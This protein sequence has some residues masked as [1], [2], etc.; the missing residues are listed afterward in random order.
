MK[1]GLCLL[2]ACLLICS[3]AVCAMAAQ[4]GPVITMQPQSPNIPH[5]G[6]AIYTVKATGSN[7]SATWYMEWQGKT[8]TISEL[9][10][11]MQPWEAYA[12]EA[13]GP[14]KLDDNT[15]AFI[16][17]GIERDLDGARIWCVIEDGHYDVTSRKAYVM[18]GNSFTAPEILDIP[19]DVT[20]EQGA[21]AEI[22][23]VA[24]APEGTQLSFVWYET[25][26]GR[27]EDMRAVNRGE[28]TTDY[29]LCDTSVVGTRNYLCKVES[30][31]GGLIYSSIVQVTV[32][33]KSQVVEAPEI[34]TKQLPEATAG[35]AYDA[36]LRC[37]D[38]NASFSVYF[39]PGKKNEFEQTGLSLSKDG[40][41]T[42]TPQN[43]GSFTFCICAAGAGG[44]DYWEYTLTVN[45]PKPQETEPVAPTTVPGATEPSAVPGPGGETVKP[46]IKPAPT[47]PTQEEPMQGG[48]PWWALVL[49]GVLA[50]GAGVVT[51]LLLAR[52]KS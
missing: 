5:Y 43:A 28:E 18:V 32:I 29:L 23:C 22:R 2:L 37:S 33:E 35:T 41:I 47:V 24:K 9:G 46:T 19:S 8:Y 3:L 1:K 15:F 10:G 44:E 13:Y 52:K 31:E 6:V 30:S 17:E 25:D 4:E 20:V 11:A 12:G 51:A 49:T 50:A 26:T 27:F 45:Q 39:N 36:Q 38:P 16:F 48:I 40:R 14:R 7:L 34:Q 21:E 42:G